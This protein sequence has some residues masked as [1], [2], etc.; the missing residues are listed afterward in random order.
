M[1]NARHETARATKKKE[2]KRGKAIGRN[3]MTMKVTNSKMLDMK[4]VWLDAT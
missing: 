1:G 4:G 3:S 2:R